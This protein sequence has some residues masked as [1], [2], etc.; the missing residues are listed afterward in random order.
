MMIN[1]DLKNMIIKK[2]MYSEKNININK[3]YNLINLIDNI[4]INSGVQIEI[5]SSLFINICFYIIFKTNIY[6]ND[7]ILNFKEIKIFDDIGNVYYPQKQ[8]FNNF[9]IIKFI[10]PVDIS[11]KKIFIFL[12]DINIISKLS[13]LREEKIRQLHYGFR[14]K[15]LSLE[16]SEKIIKE[17]REIEKKS[18]N[19]TYSSIIGE[20]K[21]ELN[22][23][24][25]KKETY[26]I[27]KVQIKKEHFFNSFVFNIECLFVYIESFSLK[28][29]YNKKSNI[30]FFL[31]FIDDLGSF[32][33]IIPIDE[34]KQRSVLY[35]PSKISIKNIDDILNRIKIK[36]E[37]HN[38][39]PF[40]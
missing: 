25:S 6:N 33:D 3:I 37:Y 1:N 39:V 22:I 2:I 36:D 12:A 8:I 17:I 13:D 31:Y 30:L 28:I 29:K 27:E 32:I 7:I 18:K 16:S 24:K 21:F 35:I 15:N 11:A 19:I 4:Y 9:N 23:E 38:M 40:C 26:E 5:I 20:W 34:D 14:N 10:P